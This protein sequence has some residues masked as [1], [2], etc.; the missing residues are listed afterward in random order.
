MEVA[1]E[2]MEAQL[3]RWSLEIEKIA[4]K[5]QGAGVRA[6]FD[7]L[8]RIDELKAAHAV[9]QSKLG[10]FKA[11]GETNR[12]RVEGELKSAWSDLVTALKNLK[13]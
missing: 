6:R 11:A 3:K 2:K 13:A 10:E 1:V 9:A 12:T 7:A 8:M 5:T 4:A